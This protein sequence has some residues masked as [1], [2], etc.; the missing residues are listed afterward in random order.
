MKTNDN[1]FCTPIFR[2]RLRVFLR[3]TPIFRPRLRY[4]YIYNG[5][6]CLP[7]NSARRNRSQSLPEFLH[8]MLFLFTSDGQFLARAAKSRSREKN[9]EVHSL[10]FAS[11]LSPMISHLDSR[12]LSFPY[13]PP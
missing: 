5:T 3:G 9:R 10:K 12:H 1:L 6:P 4:I 7:L 2:P 13:E 8:F 11:F